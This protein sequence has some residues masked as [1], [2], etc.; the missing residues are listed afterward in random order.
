[1][2]FLPDI[3]TWTELTDIATLGS[4]SHEWKK[5]D[6]AY[7]H[8]YVDQQNPASHAACLEALESFL[9]I[10]GGKTKRNSKGAL[11]ALHRTLTQKYRTLSADDLIGLIEYRTSEI[12]AVLRIFNSVSLRLKNEKKIDDAKELKDAVKEC[13]E[14]IEALKTGKEDHTPT[15]AELEQ[16]KNGLMDS[17]K[18]GCQ[19]FG[20]D[21]GDSIDTINSILT[22]E[23]F[24]LI[25]EA[26]PFIGP[27]T[28][29]LKI[30]NNLR[31]YVTNR[32]NASYNRSIRHL[33]GHN[34]MQTA[35]DSLHQMMKEENIG[36]A[37]E[38]GKSTFNILTGV[39]APAGGQQVI[40]FGMAASDLFSK[41]IEINER[42][43]RIP[44]VNQKLRTLFKVEDFQHLMLE[45]PIMSAYFIQTVD[46]NTFVHYTLGD[47]NQPFFMLLFEQNKKKI[48]DLR[49]QARTYIEKSEFELH[50]V[51]MISHHIHELREAEKKNL[52]AESAELNRIHR[53]IEIKAYNELK[54]YVKEAYDAYEAATYSNLST[55]ERLYRMASDGKAQW[56]SDASLAAVEAL[57][58]AT[59]QI[60]PQYE[61]LMIVIN[62]VRFLIGTPGYDNPPPGYTHLKKLN[63][64]GRFDSILSD[65]YKFWAG[66]YKD[67]VEIFPS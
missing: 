2:Y 49:Y 43:S 51:E 12:T 61:E 1:M 9:Q 47:I 59:N 66:R 10:K 45:W 32:V 40:K 6:D 38:I 65:R 5:L 22:P 60:T 37:K 48:E 28:E 21:A 41:A 36:F 63:K 52:V 27:A 11:S 16:Y 50:N 25:A 4:G 20:I 15:A 14:A 26:L 44:K 31:Q 19:Q 56:R 13:K 54:G 64:E 3:Q 8:F 35:I 55:F 39:F 24:F 7:K 33:A 62:L 58:R 67:K 42:N 18:S 46:D 34:S 57:K 17:Y 53:D 23:L 30:I 29:A